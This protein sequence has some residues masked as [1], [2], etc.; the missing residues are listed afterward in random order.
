[1][2]E[3]PLSEVNTAGFWV[4]P[5][6]TP[7]IPAVGFFQIGKNKILVKGMDYGKKMEER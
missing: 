6:S 3:Q 5:P 4:R 1:M 2:K 7:T